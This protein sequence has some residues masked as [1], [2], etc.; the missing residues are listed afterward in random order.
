[1]LSSTQPCGETDVNRTEFLV[2]LVVL[3][4]GLLALAHVLGWWFEQPM[5]GLIRWSGLGLAVGVAGTIPL[6][7]LFLAGRRWPPRWLR[8]IDEFMDREIVGI[9]R[10]LNLV[11][12]IAA[13]LLAGVCEEFLFRGFIQ[14][15][16]SEWLGVWWGLAL[17]SL[18]FG[19]SH[20]VT[21]GYAVVATLIGAFLGWMWI[22]TEDLGAPILTHMLYD[23]LVLM[24][25]SGRWPTPRPAWSRSEP[26]DQPPRRSE[27]NARANTDS[28]A[29]S[30]SDPRS[31]DP[32]TSRTKRP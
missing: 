20:A 2:S 8:G 28:D 21:P 14:G 1:L 25:L 6:Y 27:S 32:L 18:L 31:V 24:H 9:L 17:A 7:V 13:A 11:E 5:T 30:D 4:V 10:Q 26:G 23:G 16:L 22:A 19:V 12:L 29:D 15:G 3:E